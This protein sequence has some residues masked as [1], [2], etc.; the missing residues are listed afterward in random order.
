MMRSF[1]AG[2]AI[3]CPK[4][5]MDIESFPYKLTSYTPRALNLK[6]RRD[7]FSTNVFK[8]GSFRVEVETLPW[9]TYCDP[10]NAITD[11]CLV[12]TELSLY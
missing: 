12:L 2:Q 7:D 8:E 4:R 1:H 11:K 3:I 9:M 6:P 5:F 10:Y